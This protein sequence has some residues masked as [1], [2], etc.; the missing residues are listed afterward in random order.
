MDKS[1]SVIFDM[2]GVLVNTLQALFD[3]Y[4][5]SLLNQGVQGNREIFF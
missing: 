4:L 2:D 5:N 1:F 3:I